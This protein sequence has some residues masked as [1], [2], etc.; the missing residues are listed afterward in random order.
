TDTV[1]TPH[2][3][4]TPRTRDERETPAGADHEHAVRSW[5]SRRR[6]PLL[7]LIDDYHEAGLRSGAAGIDDAL[8]DL[9]RE[10]DQLYLV[11]A[12]R[13]VR[14]LETIGA[15]SVETLVIGPEELQLTPSM[16]QA[17]AA[18]LGVDLTTERTRKIAADLG[19]WPSAIRAGLQRAAS[20]S[21][22]GTGE[23]TLG[24]DYIAAMVQDLRFETVR[25]LLLRTSVP[26]QFDIETARIIAPEG[27]TVRMLRN[28]RA[29]GLLRESE[30]TAGTYYYPRAIR[31]ALRAVLSET[32][33]GEEQQVYED[34]MRAASGRNDP[35]QALGYATE[36][37]LCSLALALVDTQWSY[38]LSASPAALGRAATLFPRQMLAE[39]AR[40]S[41]AAKY[42]KDL[43]S[44][45]GAP[46]W[47]GV[48]S[49]SLN[50]ALALHRGRQVD[51]GQDE[52]L[53]LMQWGAGSL[54]AGNL[55]LAMYAF[56]QARSAALL[57]GVE[58]ESYLGAA[59]IA[60]VH[61]LQGEVD[62]CLNWL[63]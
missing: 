33:P 6:S 12:G 40:L 36:G 7:L 28:I 25:T 42:F 21:A 62:Q 32:R 43:P 26:G 23:V 60:L 41:V 38:L 11:I 61:A 29:A 45:D 39:N 8:L 18:E 9:I 58:S 47:A 19:G 20:G 3:V 31:S 48:D 34:L 24:N 1:G 55:D 63:E 2:A 13:T 37:R 17:L 30:T 15:L 59:G 14:A 49:A 57:N 56:S 27:N 44:E 10:N 4:D 50:A 46:I 35:A 52:L 22:Y 5:L 54:L 16:L 51:A 53:L